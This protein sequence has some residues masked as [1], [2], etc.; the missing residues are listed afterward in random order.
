LENH[1]KLKHIKRSPAIRRG[2]QFL[3]LMIVGYIGFRFSQFAGPLEKGLL[4]LVD[5]PPGV[6]A[7]LPI[8]ALVSL[9]YYV[10]TGIINGIHPSGLV[11]FSIICATTLIAR[12]GFCAWVCPIGLLSEYLSKERL[13]AIFT[14]KIDAHFEEQVAQSEALLE[15]EE[16]AS[17]LERLTDEE[18]ESL[19]MED[20]SDLEKNYISKKDRE[21][22]S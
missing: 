17:E 8:S 21:K 1:Q 19:L 4:P 10:F 11:L 9:K 3:F 20:L 14:K 2:V 6:E 15:D 16:A 12:K 5:R 13:S 18:A 22:N 7:F